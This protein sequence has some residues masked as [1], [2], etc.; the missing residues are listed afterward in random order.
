MNI[1]SIDRVQTMEARYSAIA[2]CQAACK[3]RLLLC[4]LRF[5]CT[6][7][8]GRLERRNSNYS[9][10]RALGCW[11]V[12]YYMYN[13]Y[14]DGG[15]SLRTTCTSC[16]NETMHLDQKSTPV[17]AIANNMKPSSRDCM[18]VGCQAS[19]RSKN[20]RWVQTQHKAEQC[21]YCFCSICWLG[22]FYT[23]PLP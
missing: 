10:T 20:M 17:A 22:A 9:P 3:I 14:H 15:T 21:R 18:K 7:P 4:T 2:I 1:S 23:L 8:K 12:R 13:L 19:F 11:A 5:S 16:T 6:D